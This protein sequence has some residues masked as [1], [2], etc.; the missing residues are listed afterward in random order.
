ML[1]TDS[2]ATLI[3]HIHNFLEKIGNTKLKEMGL[4][5]PQMYALAALFHSPDKKMTFK[6]LERKLSLAQSTTAGIISRLKQKELVYVFGDKDDKRIKYVE[7][8][9]LGERYCNNAI[10]ETNSSEEKVLKG[11]TPAE[12]EMLFNLLKKVYKNTDE[13]NF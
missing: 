6:E 13:K 2:C 8:T 4:T 5:V 11:L 3:R 9:A 10:E 12:K 7:I 1:E